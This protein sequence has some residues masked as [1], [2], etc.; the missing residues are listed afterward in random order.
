MGRT[1]EFAVG[2]VAIDISLLVLLPSCG[3]SQSGQGGQQSQTSAPQTAAI[4]AST[5]STT[6]QPSTQK[7]T[8][9]HASTTTPT[10]AQAQQA[11]QQPQ[12]E[13]STQLQQLID[14]LNKNYGSRVVVAG[15]DPAPGQIGLA[16]NLTYAGTKN[17]AGA[18]QAAVAY[19]AAAEKGDYAT[20]YS[21]LDPTATNPPS[22]T[23]TRTQWIQANRLVV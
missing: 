9:T 6:T 10:Q 7:T 14:T 21:M 2:I 20:T 22:P 23:F 18:L 15:T 11:Q 4:K 1:L 17:E 3:S 13:V 19:Y 8:A 16:P 12:A 5:P